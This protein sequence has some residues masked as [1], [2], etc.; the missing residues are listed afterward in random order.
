MNC[1][2][3]YVSWISSVLSLVLLYPFVSI[4]RNN[5]YKYSHITRKVIS[6]CNILPEEETESILS[7]SISVQH[8]TRI[9]QE[10]MDTLQRL[11]Y[12][13]NYT[14]TP[15]QRVPRPLFLEVKRQ[16]REDDHSPPCSSEVKNSW[17]CN[18]T[19]QYAFRAWC[20]VKAQ[21]QPNLTLHHYAASQPR[22]PRCELHAALYHLLYTEKPGS[23]HL[24]VAPLKS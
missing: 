24:Q 20:S 8:A 12:F 10:N 5:K 1:I 4:S 6:A 11:V 19:P 18:S 16:D 17:S 23:L 7:G 14:Q 3:L 9:R 21:G 15:I 22:R 2:L 13:S